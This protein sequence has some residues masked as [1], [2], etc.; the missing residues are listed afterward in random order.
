M[1]SAVP[2]SEISMSGKTVLITGATSGLGL[3]TALLLAERGAEIVMVGRDR[4]RS[5]FMRTEIAQY[6]SGRE[7][8]LFLAD[9]SSQAEIH[10]LAEKLHGSLSR[11][12]VLIN[13]AAALF[14]ERETTT[15]G[16]EK[17]FAVNHLAPFILTHLLLELLRAAPA[18]R[19]LT[20]SSEFH[21]GELDFSNLQ[22]ER[23]YNWLGAYR[24]SK[25]CNIL[26]TY[27][28][29]RRLAGSTITANCIS[30]GPTLTRLGDNMRGLPAAVPWLLKRIPSLLAMPE[31]AARTPVY[32]A[33]SPDL[34]G[35]SGRFFRECGEMRAKQITYDNSV[36]VRLW[37]LSEALCESGA[38][39]GSRTE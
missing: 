30:P 13:N 36:A 20:A 39:A 38:S 8:I 33:S 24:R 15:D 34:D 1:L 37:N 3:A 6:A 12:D 31:A 29:S 2:Q 28:L 32:V 7:P 26:F 18:G 25:L 23:R 10:G 22:G 4:T 19:V 35:V 5:N 11:L 27:E 17:T 9:L 14:A 21:S 16:L